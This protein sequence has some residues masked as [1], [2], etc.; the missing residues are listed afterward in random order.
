M[1]VLDIASGFSLPLDAATETFGILAKRGAGKSNAAVVMA[2][3]MFDAQIPWVAIDPKGDWWGLRA[4]KDGKKPGLP[5][6][7]FGGRHGDIPLEPSAGAMMAELILGQMLTC[8]LDVSE[9]TKAETIKFLTPFAERL[10][11][12]AEDEPF[13]LFLEEAHEYLPQRVGRDETRLVGAWQKIIKQGRF[14]GI[15]CTLISQRSA[16]VNKD[17][18][19]QVETLI[20]LRTTSP[21]DRA[22]VKGWV[23]VHTGATE[24]LETLPSLKTGE[25]WVWSP[26]FDTFER[27]RFRQR[28]TYDSGATPKVGEKRRAPAT[29]ADVDLE[30]IRSQMV[31]TIER[32]KENDPKELRRRIRDLEAR[33]ARQKPQ[34]EVVEKVVEVERVVE[35]PRLVEVVPEWVMKRAT[36][37][38]WDLQHLREDFAD[39]FEALENIQSGKDERPKPEV[40]L[41]RQPLA[42]RVKAERAKVVVPTQATDTTITGGARR[43]LEVLAWY[44]KEL[45]RTMLATLAGL[46]ASSG[47]YSN[48][49]SILKTSGMIEV[50]GSKVA[51]TRAGLDYI[52]EVAPMSESDLQE[53]WRRKLT[54]GAQRMFD[55]LLREYPD[56]LSRQELADAAELAASSGTYSNYLS[57]LRTNNLIEE[58]DG[59]VTASRTLFFD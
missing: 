24:M 35:V 56:G 13:H 3:E 30:A 33:L 43:M 7:V 45:T 4:S 52:G 26:V 8:V 55:I 44:P 20:V 12:L 34:I 32:V 10:L 36:E 39:F 29:L 23:D 6:P 51:P 16:S 53:Q 40:R 25:A 59:M 27:I 1:S 37:L 18:L 28:R 2:E 31:E 54:G 19:T 38:D 5:I 47:T 42:E 15:G 21:Q 41:P 57:I 22:A 49:L 14:K 17:V 46:K 58:Y 9:F 50:S 48:Y 11:R